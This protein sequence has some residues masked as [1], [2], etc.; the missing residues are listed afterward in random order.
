VGVFNNLK[1]SS[2]LLVAFGAV[3]AISTTASVIS[4]ASSG[5]VEEA[6]RW[7]THTYKVLAAAQA[8]GAAM[9]DQET[10]VRGFLIAG[11]E[12]FLQ[13]YESG[14]Q[15]YETS[16]AELKSLTADN[17]EQQQRISKLQDLAHSWREKVA[18]VEIRQMKDPA[19]VEAA[20]T[21][22]AS[23]AGKEAMDGI[24]TS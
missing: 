3:F 17:A 21:M 18:E 23:G 19:T 8:A 7:N 5:A 2:K 6:T 12:D 1:L 22:E 14:V 9:V 13:P 11:D 16:V 10:G 20:R 4:Y 24:R 15:R